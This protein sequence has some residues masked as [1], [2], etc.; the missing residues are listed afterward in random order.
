MELVGRNGSIQM[1]MLQDF[2]KV[3]LMVQK[4]RR[5]PVDM[6]VYPIIYRVL[7]MPGGAGFHPSTV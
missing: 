5:S 4:I 1:E 6:V 2:Y 7:Y 3:L